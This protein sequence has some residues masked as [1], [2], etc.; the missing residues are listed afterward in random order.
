MSIEIT[1]KNPGVM[2]AAKTLLDANPDYLDW[3]WHM[4]GANQDNEYYSGPYRQV[5][6]HHIQMAESVRDEI[7]EECTDV[8]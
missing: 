8:Y 5:I 7:L 2:K 6:A 1:H 3:D 4:K